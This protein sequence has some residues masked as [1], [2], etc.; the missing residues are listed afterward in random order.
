MGYTPI[1]APEPVQSYRKDYKA[2]VQMPGDKRD[3]DVYV[4]GG[5]AEQQSTIVL[6][7]NV[8]IATRRPLL[9]R[10]EAGSG[11]SSLAANVAR[12]LGWR[13]YEQVVTSRTQAQDLLWQFDAVRRLGDAQVGATRRRGRAG[14]AG[15]NPVFDLHRYIDPGVLWWALDPATARCRGCPSGR[16]DIPPAPNPMRWPAEAASAVVLIDEIDKA[17]PDVP[18]NLL[19]PLGSLQFTVHEVQATITADP[20]RFPLIVI[21]TNEERELPSAFL[22]RC[23]QVTLP[24]P[25]QDDLARI[26]IA[27]FGAEKAS[28]RKP[29]L[30]APLA[31]K[32]MQLKAEHQRKGIRPPS[33]AEYLDA[34][35]ACLML[36]I[37]P[38]DADWTELLGVTLEKTDTR[39]GRGG[40]PR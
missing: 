3:G 5:S 4:Y 10:G 1:F 23:V 38:G 35:R 13:Y 37:G 17:D 26:A 16:G 28:R 31:E 25:T 7:V 6:A 20:E 36:G 19:V 34:V 21:T 27:H 18:N 32:T 24:A 39:A 30:Y 40:Q 29:S 22:R 33:T 12:S 14:V 8:A 15:R 9:V 2:A 11:K